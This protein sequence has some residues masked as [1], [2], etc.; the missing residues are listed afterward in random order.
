MREGIQWGPVVGGLVLL[1]VGGFAY[2]GVA[3][4]SWGFIWTRRTLGFGLLWWGLAG[5][6]LG[7]GWPAL[8]TAAGSL[9]IGLP[10]LVCWLIGLL[11]FFWMP[12][13]LQP[14]WYRDYRQAVA[15]SRPG[16]SR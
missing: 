5:V 7:L 4:Q 12:R 13:V 15:T 10:A 6:L 14:R 9:L 11:S 1:A 16:G 2:S 8:D 3:R